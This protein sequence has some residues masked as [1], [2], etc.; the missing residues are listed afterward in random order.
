MKKILKWMGIVILTLVTLA[1]STAF[2]LQNTLKNRLVKQYNIAPKVIDIPT[3][4]TALAAGKIWVTALC[5][6]CHGENLAGNVMIND[7][8]LGIISAPNI[9]SGGVGK[10]YTD[11]DWEKAIRHGVAKDGRSL[12]I[13]SSKYLHYMTD[14]HIGQLIAYLKTVPAATSEL[15]ESKTTLLCDVLIQ[16]GAF[17]DDVIPAE[18]IDHK[19]PSHTAPPKEPTVAYGDYLVKVTGCRSCHGKELNGAKHPDPAVTIPASNLTPGGPLAA[20]GQDGFIKTMRTGTTP[21]GKQ[22]DPK[23]MP[24][25]Q[26]GTYD[27]VQLKAIY[28]YLMSL[29]KMEMAEIK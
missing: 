9:T 13:M 4:S 14:E 28:A 25:K 7:S 26:L 24:W 2:Y 29:P 19:S 20:F 6:D 12:R 18:Q 23:H 5:S 16:V 8:G 10:I 1:A 21:M 17:G 27:D 11:L 15:P 3:D 22:M